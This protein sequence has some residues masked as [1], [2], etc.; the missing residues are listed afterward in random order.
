LN[1][2]T[3][4]AV[5]VH[6]NLFV[7]DFNNSRVLEYDIPLQTAA[8]TSACHLSPCAATAV[9][10]QSGSFTSATCGSGDAKTLCIPNG[11]GVDAAEHVF[12]ADSGN[13]RVLEY[14]EATLPP[15]NVTASSVFG[16]GDNPPS[17]VTRF[18]NFGNDTSDVGH[19]GPDSMCGPDGVWVD[20]LSNLWV[21][22]ASNH[23]ILRFATSK[24][25]ANLVLGQNTFTQNANDDLG[26]TAGTKGSPVLWGAAAVA[27]DT[28]VPANRVYVADRNNNRVLG[29]NSVTALATG[30][31]ATLV[32]GQSSM[33]SNSINLGLGASAKSI[34]SPTGVAVDEAGRLYVADSGNSRVL[35]Y[36]APFG[37]CTVSPCVGPAATR[38]FGQNGSFTSGSCANGAGS[39]PKPAANLMCIPW[40]IAVDHLGHL[41]V[42]DT[43]N[44]RVLVFNAPLAKQSPNIVIGQPRVSAKAPYTFTAAPTNFTS[45]IG[46]NGAPGSNNAVN[47]LGMFTPYAVAVDS[48]DNL[49]VADTQNNRVLVVPE[50]AV[51]SNV[52]PSEVIGQPSGSG[53]GIAPAPAN[54]TSSI[55][56]GDSNLTDPFHV[57]ALGLCDPIGVALDPSGNLYVSDNRNSRVLEFN[58]PLTNQRA[59]IV[60]GQGAN[61][62]L[63]T[64][65]TSDVC[66]GASVIV[67]PSATGLKSMG[68]RRKF[69][70]QPVR[71]GLF[72]QPGP[73]IPSAI[74]DANRNADQDTDP[75]T[76]REAYA[77]ANTEAHLTWC[78]RVESN[79]ARPVR[80]GVGF[81]HNPGEEVTEFRRERRGNFDPTIMVLVQFSNGVCG[82]LML[83]EFREEVPWRPIGQG[84]AARISVCS[85]RG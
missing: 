19:L 78:Q 62:A 5:D 33:V 26:F 20:A 16:Q 13:N 72:Q 81:G 60:F 43:G 50:G 40:N 74:G 23:R 27:I 77:K 64:A 39:N 53:S 79:S 6:A 47:R 25:A 49:Y 35:E 67:P 58:H 48:A 3:A 70:R 11:V 21:A 57:N 42:A 56:F 1:T 41:Y 61:G 9:F 15:R 84:R 14:T 31:P 46:F 75:H 37:G 38:V 52:T 71:G 12:I 22:D 76:N 29:W 7:A 36:D 54:F 45:N 2:P 10:G 24:P 34:Y 28:S 4:V 65:F 63:A 85:Y 30:Q 80:D 32:I 44:S 59:D 8:P 18:C 68:R 69:R 73:A 82:R 66:Y 51:P 17:F 83:N 55:C